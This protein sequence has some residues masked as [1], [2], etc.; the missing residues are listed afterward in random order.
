MHRHNSKQCISTK[1]FVPA[2]L[3]YFEKFRTRSEAMKREQQFKSW[4][5]KKALHEFIK[6]VDGP[7]V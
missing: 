5:S 2:K 3:V 1:A 6:T 4:K 7:I